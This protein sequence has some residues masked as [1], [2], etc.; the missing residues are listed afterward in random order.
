MHSHIHDDAYRTRAH[1]TVGQ[2]DGS[3]TPGSGIARGHDHDIRQG[4]FRRTTWQA[5][6]RANDSQE[7]A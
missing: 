5:T 2:T 6:H 3:C 1:T 4:Q 7:R